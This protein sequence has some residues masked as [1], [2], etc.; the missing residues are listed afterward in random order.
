MSNNAVL[1]NYRNELMLQGSLFWDDNHLRL[2]GLCRAILQEY[3]KV[4]E[5]P[6]NGCN[7]NVCCNWHYL[8]SIDLQYL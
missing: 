2:L 4:I 7:L 1:N 3:P 5:L 6:A 8:T